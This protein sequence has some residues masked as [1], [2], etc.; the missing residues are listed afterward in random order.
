MSLLGTRNKLEYRTKVGEVKEKG[1]PALFE[2]KR[3]SGA[4]STRRALKGEPHSFGLKASRRLRSS[5][6]GE[7]KRGTPPFFIHLLKWYT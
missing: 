6:R 7:R 4:G 3:R 5:L 1:N 2:K